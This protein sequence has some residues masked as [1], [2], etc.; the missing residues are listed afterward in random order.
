[1]DN[2]AVSNAFF[3]FGWSHGWY[4]GSVSHALE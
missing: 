4:D 3:R 2:Q 1:M